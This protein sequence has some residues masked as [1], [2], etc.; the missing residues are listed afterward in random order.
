MVAGSL[1]QAARVIIPLPLMLECLSSSPLHKRQMCGVQ[2]TLNDIQLS[3]TSVS[4]SGLGLIV[5]TDRRISSTPKA[6]G[7]ANPFHPAPSRLST[8][9]YLSAF[10]DHRAA[11]ALGV[12]PSLAPRSCHCPSVPAP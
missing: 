11:S 9:G 1:R 6:H 10:L 7:E 2:L 8:V 12:L 4:V 5:V 3:L